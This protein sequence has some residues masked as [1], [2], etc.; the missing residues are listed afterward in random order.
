MVH[1]IPNYCYFDEIANKVIVLR[2]VLK[3]GKI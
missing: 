3:Y 1:L 2:N